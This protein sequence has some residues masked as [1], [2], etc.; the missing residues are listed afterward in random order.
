MFALEK[1]LF[2]EYSDN[3]SITT[4]DKLDCQPCNDG[5]F[6]VSASTSAAGTTCPNGY[7]CSTLDENVGQLGKYPCPA[8]TFA[9]AGTGHADQNAACQICDAGFYCNGADSPKTA[10]PAGYFC[11]T[12]TK[13]STQ[14]PCLPGTK[15]NLTQQTS[16]AACVACS[17]GEYCPLGTANAF[18][19]PPN[20][21]CTNTTPVQDAA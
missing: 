21:A 15:N 17:G 9:K 14:F 16:S 7:W 6:C 20:S 8:G 1:C 19:C 3:T 13:W 10:C 5:A 11:P 18:A 12:G 4:S 2:G